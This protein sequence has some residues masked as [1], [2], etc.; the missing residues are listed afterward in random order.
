MRL[1]C[2]KTT[3]PTVRVRV[4]RAIQNVGY[5]CTEERDE[6]VTVAREASTPYVTSRVQSKSAQHTY[7]ERT[8]WFVK[9]VGFDRV[10]AVGHGFAARF[11][12]VPN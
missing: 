12:G 7:A 11:A 2:Q 10:R 6:E 3:E 9:G 8:L 1:L 4:G 5:E